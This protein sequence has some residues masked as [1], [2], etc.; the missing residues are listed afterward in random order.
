MKLL[1]F[2]CFF[3]IYALLVAGRH[4]GYCGDGGGFDFIQ[5]AAIFFSKKNT[6]HGTVLFWLENV[7]AACLDNASECAIVLA[8]STAT[9]VS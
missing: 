5:E 3:N 4:R 6:R 8:I 9:P 1:P 2:F 7:C